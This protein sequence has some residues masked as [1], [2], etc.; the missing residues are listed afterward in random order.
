VTRTR[1]PLPTHVGD[2]P[3]LPAT[4]HSTVTAGLA[5]LG[6]D[7]STD[8]RGAIDDHLRLLLAWT[9]AIN[10]T[11]VRDP[12]AAATAHALDALSAVP[13]IRTLG[14]D[15]FLDLGSGGGYPAIPLAVAVPADALLVES[16]AKKA[17]FL[18]VTVAAIGLAGRIDVAAT[19]A[20]VLAGDPAHRGRWP[21]VTARAVASL[22]ALIELGLPLLV[23][24]GAIVAWKR[25]AD[26]PAGPAARR[27]LAAGR[28]AA[29]AVG[30]GDPEIHPVELAGL[31]RHH[32][33]VVRKT[34]P[35]P[36]R[37]PRD[38]AARAGRPW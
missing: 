17:R 8:Q 21:L 34:T 18:E 10:L 13:L 20:E 15:R 4:Y 1:E 37:Y 22:D 3:T 33:V 2:L 30:G 31:E 6:L 29:A 19:R 25:W 36:E 35:S 11:A 28:R 5:S 7:L 9:T 23:V 16:I 26:G 32:L 38:P 12:Q 24:G 27:E 14:I